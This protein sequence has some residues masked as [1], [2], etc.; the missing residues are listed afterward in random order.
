MFSLRCL[1]L[2]VAALV[3]VSPLTTAH[4]QNA[5]GS[6]APAKKTAVPQHPPLLTAGTTAPNFTAY[7]KDGNVVKLS[8][9]KGK[10]VVLDFWATWCGPC[11]RS[12]PHTAELARKMADKGVVVFAVNVWD[13]RAAFN[14]W[15]PEHADFAP[16]QF[17]IDTIPLKGQDVAR[18]FYNVWGIPTQYVIDR[19]GKIVAGFVVASPSDLEKA[20][21][22]ADPGVFST[23]PASAPSS[24]LQ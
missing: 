15:V 6:A 20:I 14:K 5:T 23:P 24:A 16:I 3:A 18:K 22:K 10:I 12:L 2:A 13:T 11:M 8:D 9:F 17:A 21:T 19:D 4:A 1:P 7:D